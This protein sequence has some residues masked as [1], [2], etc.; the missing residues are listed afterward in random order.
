MYN[1]FDDTYSWEYRYTP[2]TAAYIEETSQLFSATFN[3][4]LNT[5][6]FYE[7]VLS[8]YSNEYLEIPDDPDNPGQGLYPDDFLQYDQWEYYQDT[9]GNGRY[10][11]PEPF[12]NVNGDT[13][14]YW[15]GDQYT[16]GDALGGLYSYYWDWFNISEW[17]D[18][19]GDEFYNRYDKVKWDQA[20]SA[21]DTM[22]WDWDQDGYIDNADGEPF[23]DLNGNGQWDAGDNLLWDTNGNGIYDENHGS[24]INVDRPEPY[25]DGDVNM[26]EPFNDVNKNGVYDRGID[27]FL[28]SSDPAINMDLNRNS[29]YDG[30]NSTWTPGV[31]YEDMNGNGLYDYPNGRYDSGEPFTDLNH[32]GQW[33]AQDGFYDYGFNQWAFYQNRKSVINTLDFKL[34]KQLFSEL[35]MK[36]GFQLKYNELHMADLRYPYYPYDG[37]PDGGPWPDVGVFR[38]FYD[39]YPY[40]GAAFVDFKLEFG[41]LIAKLGTRVDLFKQ[42]ANIDELVLEDFGGNESD[43]VSVKVS[44]RVGISYPITERAKI[45][46][47]YG[48]FYQLPEFQYMY[49]QA[50]QASNA[51]GIIGNYNL[52]YKKTIQYSIGITY[53]LSADYVLDVSGFYKDVFGLVN[54]QEVSI[55]PITT[56]AYENSDYARTRGLELELRKTYGHYIS[57]TANYTYSFAYGKSSSESS[58]YFDQFYNRSIPIKEFPLDWDVRQQLQMS[59]NLSISQSDKPVLFGMAIPNDWDL[60]LIWVYGTGYPYTPSR[61]YPGLRLLAGESPQTNSLRYPP[62]SE[63]NIRFIKNFSLIGLDYTFELWINNLFDTQNI[64]RVYSATGRPDTGTNIGGN[65]KEGSEFAADP[66]YIGPGRNIRVGLALNF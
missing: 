27:V 54:S 21:F 18:I 16:Q 7:I 39:Q 47:N 28:M 48:H 58:N 60:S 8:R 25:V 3:H 51:F 14:M 43:K 17:W 19:H 29:Q 40:Q 23:V 50:T 9:N 2:A 31:P 11:Q 65:V 64:L 41:S 33:D 45:Y 56:N 38:D 55:G 30:P 35:E 13:V 22:Y 57:G 24:P 63:V 20:Q 62:N 46:F 15:G 1:R 53:G 42:S 59:F 34:I 32:N 36:T 37:D 5:S 44:P 12:I 6:T 66:S 26:G 10:D 61:D 52:D 49:R 4:Q